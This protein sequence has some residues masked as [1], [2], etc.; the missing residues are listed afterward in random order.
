MPSFEEMGRKLDRELDRLRQVAESKVKPAT[1]EKAAG[2]LRSVSASPRKC[3][4][5]LRQ[6][7]QAVEVRL[8]LAHPEAAEVTLPVAAAAGSLVFA[9][10]PFDNGRALTSLAADDRSG[11]V[12]GLGEMLAYPLRLPGVSSVVLGIR[13]MTELQED[14]EA[15]RSLGT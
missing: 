7:A 9:R 15:W 14:I 4:A 8:N 13:S 6:G 3:A 5:A 10:S 1:C 11:R 12:R 2:V